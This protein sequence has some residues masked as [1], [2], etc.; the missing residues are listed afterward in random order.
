MSKNLFRYVSSYPKEKD[1]QPG[2]YCY[3]KNGWIVG[4]IVSTDY[5]GVYVKYN[6]NERHSFYQLDVSDQYDVDSSSPRF[7]LAV[8]TVSEIVNHY[9]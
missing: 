4:P 9:F 5:D 3:L 6:P 2:L 7:V 8:G 1:C